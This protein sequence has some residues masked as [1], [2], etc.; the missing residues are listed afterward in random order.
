MKQLKMIWNHLLELDERIRMERLLEIRYVEESEEEVLEP[1]MNDDFEEEDVEL[2][3]DKV[4]EKE[5]F[6][7]ESSLMEIAD[8]KHEE[9]KPVKRYR[10]KVLIFKPETGRWNLWKENFRKLDYEQMNSWLMNIGG[11]FG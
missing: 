9:I 7:I 4:T 2:D 3:D 10:G 6:E 8:L 1:M 11:Y 5:E